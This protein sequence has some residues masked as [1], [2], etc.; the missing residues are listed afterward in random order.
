MRR[1]K[2]L[3]A[4]ED[5]ADQEALVQDVEENLAQLGGHG[6]IERRVESQDLVSPPPS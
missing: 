6:G 2:T 5:V 1:S 3:Q 4:R